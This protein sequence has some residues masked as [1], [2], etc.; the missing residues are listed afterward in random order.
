MIP[1]P[2]TATCTWAEMGDYLHSLCMAAPDCWRLRRTVADGPEPQAE[3]PEVDDRVLRALSE[4]VA[5]LRKTV[6][7]L[8]LELRAVRAKAV[9]EAP[10]TAAPK[11]AAPFVDRA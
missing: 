9:A 2:E 5:S 3:R 11:P 7:Q 8:E 1:K 4:Q 6:G 10:R